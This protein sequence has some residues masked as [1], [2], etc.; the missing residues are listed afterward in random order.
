MLTDGAGNLFFGNPG[1]S[2]WLNGTSG[3]IFY[4]SGS[5]GI[6][7]TTPLAL[8]SI[9]GSATSTAPL[10]DIA[11]SSGTSLFRVSSNGTVTVGNTVLQKDGATLVNV[12]RFGTTQSTAALGTVYG[13]LA[14][15]QV[16][17]PFVTSLTQTLDYAAIQAAINWRSSNTTRGAVFVPQGT[18][19]LGG[20]TL[21]LTSGLYLYGDMPSVT[22]VGALDPGYS[23]IPNGG[24]WID[25]G[26][27][28]PCVTGVG[29]NSVDMQKIGFHTL[30]AIGMQFGTPTGVNDGIA[31]SHASDLFLV[32]NSSAIKSSALSG[33]VIYNSSFFD[34]QRIYIAYVNTCAEFHEGINSAGG[35]NSEWDNTYCYPFPHSAANGNVSQYPIIIENSSASFTYDAPTFKTLQINDYG[36]STMSF[37][38]VRGEPSYPVVNLQISGLDTEGSGTILNADNANGAYIRQDPNNGTSSNNIL[39][40]SNVL[41]YCLWAGQTGITVTDSGTYDLFYGSWGTPNLAGEYYDTSS[42]HDYGSIGWWTVTSNQYQNHMASTEFEARG[43]ITA[44]IAAVNGAAGVERAFGMNTGGVQRWIIGADSSPESG[45]NAG[46][47]LAINAYSDSGTYLG[48]YMLMSRATG[49]TTWSG[50]MQGNAGFTASGT[51]NNNI[52][53]SLDTTTGYKLRM[54]LNDAAGQLYTD[55]AVPLKLGSNN[56]FPFQ[57][58]TA[59]QMVAT[60]IDPTCSA[61]ADIGKMWLNNTSAT[62]NHLEVCAE[63]SSTIG[64]QTIF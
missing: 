20:S 61:T 32:G 46:S 6:N 41:A 26:G 39:L 64:W 3:T 19:Y 58:G 5:I 63:V 27:A 11:S 50:P 37:I 45:S 25:C 60:S 29:V 22:N 52:F 48:Q 8:L 54:S 2:Q 17:Y 44:S 34:T 21:V 49:A 7:T 53:T 18:Y 13:T 62:A 14:A 59:A 57:V 28:S 42:G 35:V 24:T 38:Y 23:W 33:F 10:F 56:A 4:S 12:Q 30:G 31:L 1:S 47:T 51:Q 15:A 55:H 9:V 43:G 16:V 36:D 40:G